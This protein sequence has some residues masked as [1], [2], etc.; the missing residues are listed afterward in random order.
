MFSVSK[1]E[2]CSRDILMPFRNLLEPR[3]QQLASVTTV[4]DPIVTWRGGTGSYKPF[5]GDLQIRE[6]MLQWAK[7][8]KHQNTTDIEVSKRDGSKGLTHAEQ[9][10]GGILL[11]IDG[12][13]YSQRLQ[14][15]FQQDVAAT[16]HAGFFTDVLMRQAQPGKDYFW[17]N[18]S[19]SGFDSMVK[20][21]RNNSSRRQ[22]LAKHGK[23]F[24][25]SYIQSQLW[26]YYV[27]VL[28][29]DYATKVKV[30][31]D[32]VMWDQN[33]PLGYVGCYE[34]SDPRQYPVPLWKNI[35]EMF[36]T[37]ENVQR[38]PLIH[39][40]YE[41]VK[42]NCLYFALQAGGLE[43]WGGTVAMNDGSIY[44]LLDNADCRATKPGVHSHAYVGR[45][46][47]NAVYRTADVMESLLAS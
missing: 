13:S 25:D 45:N 39:C 7:A 30:V 6:K 41:A 43:C 12:H 42:S 22:Q 47:K 16:A 36:W 34:D 35:H 31:D 20:V 15:Y 28:V 40:A 9:I 23:L 21:L 19:R 3:A 26:R 11:D 38:E 1:V 33:P 2:Q 10:Q 44:K 18:F 5:E 37:W 24:G 14:W 29:M 32:M 46:W 17:F 27:G 8:L 4:L